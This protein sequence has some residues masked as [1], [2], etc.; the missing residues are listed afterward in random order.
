MIK[1]RYGDR[2][3][4]LQSSSRCFTK[5][6]TWYNKKLY[7]IIALKFSFVNEK[8]VVSLFPYSVRLHR[9][10]TCTDKQHTNRANS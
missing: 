8:N 10:S 4:T 3:V 2:L 6:K 7:T 1:N 9:S 5:H